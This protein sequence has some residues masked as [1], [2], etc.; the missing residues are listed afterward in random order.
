MNSVHLSPK[1]V[2]MFNK[3]NILCILRHAKIKC[4]KFFL[5]SKK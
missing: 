4:I 3:Q 2:K 1:R 5:I